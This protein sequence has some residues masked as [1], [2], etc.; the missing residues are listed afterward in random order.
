MPH[1]APSWA[2]RSS[3]AST[4]PPR[5]PT[6]AKLCA[7]AK[8]ASF[9]LA[10]PISPRTSCRPSPSRGLSPC[11]DWTLSGLCGRRPGARPTC[12]SQ[13]TNSPSGWR[14]APLQISGR[15]KR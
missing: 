12:W 9:T 3:R 15:S 4:G 2:T 14:C 6:P 7:L 11:E 13:S 10:R 5:L 8:G 1:R